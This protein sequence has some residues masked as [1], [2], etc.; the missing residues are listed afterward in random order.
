[1]LGTMGGVA[2]SPGGALG[3]IAALGYG[4]YRMV[5]NLATAS[6]DLRIES[7]RLGVGVEYF[8]QLGFAARRTGTDMGTVTTAIE[9][10]RVK[11][12]EAIANPMGSTSMAFR[13]A[14]GVTQEQLE[15]MT[16]EQLALAGGNINNPAAVRTALGR[17]GF[18]AQQALQQSTRPSPVAMDVLEVKAGEAMKTQVGLIGDGISKVLVQSMLG[19]THFFY[20]TNLTQA[21][22]VASVDQERRKIATHESEKQAIYAG[23]G[24]ESIP[25]L[26]YPQEKLRAE[27]V[28]IK[29]KIYY[30]SDQAAREAGWES[31]EYGNN[32]MRARDAQRAIEDMPHGEPAG[33]YDVSEM[34]GYNMVQSM[35][36]E[37]QRRTSARNQGWLIVNEWNGGM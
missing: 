6:R 16:P 33:A 13:A 36:V 31:S 15:N 7:T 26:L 21:G 24:A 3:G 20:G 32:I 10:L 11:Q 25:G 34:S 19:W 29:K 37:S 28:Q 30:A 1:M 8:Q 14:L 5:E 2:M 18:M 9:H 35:A 27:M 22:L 4:G 12:A 17:G 23:M